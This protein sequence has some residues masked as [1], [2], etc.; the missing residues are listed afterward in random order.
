MSPSRRRGP[1]EPEGEAPEA[2]AVLDAEE[3]GDKVVEFPEE[4]S[5]LASFL[6][7]ISKKADDYA[8]RMFEE[9]E[10][11]DP[12]EVRRLETLIP[13]T[14]QETEEDLRYV[15]RPRRQEPPPPDLPPR[16]W[17]APTA[18]ALRGSGSAP[19]WSFFWPPPLWSPACSPRS[20]SPSPRSWRWD[21]PSS[22][23]SPPGFWG[24]GMLLSLDVLAAGLWRGVRLKV[25]MDTLAALSCAFTLADTLLLAGS[26]DRGGQLSYCPAALF[27]L[28]FLLHGTYHKRCALRLSCRTAAAAAEPYLVTL[29]EGKWNG[30]D[31]YAKWSG[32]PAGFG[33]QIQMDDG[34]Q[35]IY[36]VF[37][38]VLLLAC[39]VFSL[40]A[41]FG[42]GEG[43]HLMW[44]LSAT[45]TAAAG[46][47]GALA[48][49]RSFHKVARRVSQSGGALAGWPGAAGS[50]RGNRVLITDLD[51]FPPGFV[52]LNGIKVFGDFSV[53][54]V[55]GYTATLIRDSGCGLEKL[56]HDLLRTQGAI[57]RRADSLC[58]Y[59]G[60]G[61][62]ANIR[63]YQVLVG[64]AAF[65]NLME[66][67]LPQGLHV[68]NAVF[69]AVDGELAGI[70]ALNYSL[71]DMVFPSLDALMR[72]RV[73]P[74]LATRDFNLIPA[75][76]HQR[77]KLAVDKMDFP[78]VERRREL[79]DPDQP[80]NSTITAVLCREGPAALRRL[81]GGGPPP[82][83]E[84]PAG[85]GSG[86][87]G[88]HHW[89][90]AGRL[91]HV[92]GCLRLPVPPESVDLPALLAGP[93]VVPHQLGA[94][95]LRQRKGE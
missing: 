60:G 10:Q 5:P 76:L 91:P 86:L 34:A 68:K 47:G 31:T 64:S 65:M 37:C 18:R 43:E 67:S 40:L 39:I 69:C 1:S 6:K 36:R 16:S 90:A 74:V 94:P 66:V 38:P 78:P 22:S 63:G 88:L 53:E 83:P 80:H 44:C 73:A 13:G 57:F 93:G 55:V 35:R 95:L 3:N 45:F 17:P 54:R 2:D 56:F 49:G 52:E 46:F 12:E 41:S 61:L 14:D 42:I 72:E 81:G 77:F 48:Y 75:M 25:G 87:R 9:S 20:L 24:P 8:D 50:R 11:M 71:P 19:Y 70:F 92:G 27:G 21:I 62:S 7:D 82:A 29:D 4:E 51:L 28:F 33:S 15:R 84:H 85:G 32:T 30:W 59:E 26:Q 23:G 89:A 79:S 58:C